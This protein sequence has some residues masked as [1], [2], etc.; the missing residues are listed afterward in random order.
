MHPCQMP[1][2]AGQSFAGQVVAGQL[3][4]R[5]EGFLYAI[6]YGRI[7][8]CNLV[9][10]DSSLQCRREEIILYEISIGPQPVG[11]RPI[12]PK[13]IVPGTIGPGKLVAGESFAGQVQSHREGFL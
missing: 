5:R 8:L 7:P 2:V 10:K 11:P 12:C 9:E 1:M 6:L 13:T 3:Q 4:S